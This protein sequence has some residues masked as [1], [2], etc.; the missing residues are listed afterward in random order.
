MSQDVDLFKSSYRLILRRARIVATI[1]KSSSSVE[2]LKSLIDSGMNVIR[3]NF[4]HGTQESHGK[5]ITAARTICSERARPIAI[6]GDLCGPKIRVGTFED[7]SIELIEGQT[8][9]IVTGGNIVGKPGMI[10]S[11][12]PELIADIK[13]GQ[14]IYFDDG[15]LEVEV[16]Q[17]E[18]AG[19]ALCKVNKGGVLKNNKGM[20]LPGAAL[21]TPAV[22]EKDLQDLEFA[23]K[24][25]LEYVALSFVRH[26]GEI[27]EL[28][29]RIVELSRSHHPDLF[30]DHPEG[31][32]LTRVIAKIEKP[33]ALDDIRA[34]V[35]ESDGIMIARGDLGVE[36][37]PERVPIVQTELM[38]LGN[39]MNK[40]VIVATQMLESMMEHPRPTRAEVTDVAAAV[41]GR[42]DA[43]M[44][45][46]ETAAGDYPVESVQYM[47]RIIREVESNQWAR[48]KWG[49]LDAAV[50]VNPVPNA[51]ARACTLLS[52]DMEIRAINV[53]SRTG[54]TARMISSARPKCPVLA[55]SNEPMIVNQ[56]ALL[57]GVYPFQLNEQLTLESFAGVA[58]ETCKQMKIA[59]PG[60]YILLV[61]SPLEK[62]TRRSMS[63]VIIYEIQ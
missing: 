18:D 37:P 27:R 10:P 48:G 15:L 12:Y 11:Q 16:I 63:S 55:F 23:V 8:V 1:G 9:S 46:G 20:N 51:I 42:A 4:S 54:R 25:R 41:A 57:W 59:G 29:R 26:A 56:M 61:S 22:T 58:A 49:R 21:S 50:S 35:E 39:E 14:I 34:I 5:V 36:M 40:P 62:G 17:I 45:S 2:V 52:H 24:Q 44:L 60:Q 6:L 19:R 3:L 7:G 53:L 30:E 31:H 38:R 32:S 33:E 47:D 43:V 28:K 13:P